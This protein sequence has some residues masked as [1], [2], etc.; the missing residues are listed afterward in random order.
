[1]LIRNPVPFV[2]IYNDFKVLKQRYKS[3]WV[4][5]LTKNG[6]K[7]CVLSII[8]GF[9]ICIAPA[10]A[11]GGLMEEITGNII[12]ARETLL[13]HG[14]CGILY[15]LFS[16][17][18]IVILALTGPV[19]VF[20]EVIYEVSCSWQLISVYAAIVDNRVHWNRVRILEDVYRAVGDGN[21]NIIGCYRGDLSCDNLHSF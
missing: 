16:V 14:I 1:M 17:Q 11:F 7:Q 15:S 5:W 9:M 8:F 10:I 19:L 6:I 13:A 21:S 18:P 12:G 3:D 2:G 4:D 20:E